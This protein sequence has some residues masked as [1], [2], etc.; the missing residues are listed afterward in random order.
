MG[1]IILMTKLDKIVIAC[2]AIF[3]FFIMFF[4]VTKNVVAGLF[5]S[6]L[7]TIL[8]YQVALHLNNRHKDKKNITLAEMEK[9]FA[10]MGSA[11]IEYFINATPDYFCPQAID[12]GFIL[13]VNCKKIAI[14]PNYKFSASSMDDISKFYRTAKS[15]DL[16]NVYVLSKLNDRNTVLFAN[17]LDID[18]SFVPSRKV[19]KFLLKRNCLPKSIIKKRAK[20]KKS[21]LKEILSNI[22]IKKRAKYFFISGITLGLLSFVTPIKAYYI[23]ICVICI[24]LGIGCIIKERV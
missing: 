18:F 2:A 5:I 16:N 23:V 7:L 19:Y 14:F 20:M 4:A 6:L 10:L 9:L 11:Q 22:F 24:L 3:V 1:K 8:T 12:F 17:S 15:N 21:D 13:T